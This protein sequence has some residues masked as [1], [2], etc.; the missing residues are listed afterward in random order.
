VRSVNYDTGGKET[1]VVE[2]TD[3]SRQAFP[4]SLFAVPAGFQKREFPGMGRG[5]Q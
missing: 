2:L 1:S 5:R 3:A 4:D